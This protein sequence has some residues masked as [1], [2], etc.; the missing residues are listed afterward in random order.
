MRLK[1]KLCEGFYTADEDQHLKFKKGT[2]KEIAQSVK[3]AH[4]ITKKLAI[5]F[6]HGIQIDLKPESSVKSLTYL[7]G[8]VKD[9]QSRLVLAQLE[10]LIGLYET[11]EFQAPMLPKNTPPLEVISIFDRLVNDQTYVEYS[12][13]VAQLGDPSRRERAMIRVRELERAVRS[14]SFIS[15]GWN[16]AAKAVKAWSGVPVPESQAISSLIQG[17]TLPTLIDMQKAR[18]SAVDMWKKS[19]LV[20]APL[21]RDGAPLIE[22][23]IQWL[24]PLNSMKV[25]SNDNRPF[26]LGSVGELLEALNEAQALF[27]GEEN[28]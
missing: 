1:L 3:H 6:N 13:S 23:D 16:Y 11:V 4:S 7:R 2:P 28:V 27:E 12:D 14:L 22:G 25:Y 20:G 21:N 8:V 9:S 24:P 10:A 5:G 15:T 19:D 17:K 26:S 18:E